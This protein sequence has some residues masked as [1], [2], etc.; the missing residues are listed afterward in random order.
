LVRFR[1]VLLRNSGRCLCAHPRIQIADISPAQNTVLRFPIKKVLFILQSFP[2]GWPSPAHTFSVGLSFTRSQARGFHAFFLVSLPAVLRSDG[3]VARFLRLLRILSAYAADVLQDDRDP[4]NSKRPAEPFG[5]R[6]RWSAR[7][8]TG[9]TWSE[10]IPNCCISR[11][12][13]L[14]RSDESPQLLSS[15]FSLN[16]WRIEID[17]VPCPLPLQQN[18]PS[19]ARSHSGPNVCGQ[20]PM[21]AARSPTKVATTSRAAEVLLTPPDECANLGRGR[22]LPHRTP[23]AGT[24]IRRILPRTT[25]PPAEPEHWESFP[26]AREADSPQL[27]RSQ[28]GAERPCSGSALER[29]CAINAPPPYPDR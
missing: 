17:W 1:E 5:F 27:R 25:A 19:R 8:P 29:P 6:S 23:A 18:Q 21:R 2:Q 9:D 14:A 11:R 4:P 12:A 3:T 24:K 16:G 28:R 20:F 7:L 26:P 13:R 15:A 22:A 10:R